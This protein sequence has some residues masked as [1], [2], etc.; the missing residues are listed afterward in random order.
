M[1]DNEFPPYLYKFKSLSSN[2]DI[3]YIREI[4]LENKLY[5]TSPLKFNDPFDSNPVRII[6]GTTKEKEMYFRRLCRENL[7]GTPRSERRA[8]AKKLARESSEVQKNQ[9]EEIRKHTMES[10]G[11][12]CF[13]GNVENILLWSHYADSH[14]GICLRFKGTISL[15]TRSNALPVTY[16]KDRPVLDLSDRDD[17]RYLEKALLTKSSDWS[18]EDEHRIVELSG[19]G[20]YEFSP[21]LLDGVIFGDRT[22]DARRAE[23]LDMIRQRTPIPKLLQCRIDDRHFRLLLETISL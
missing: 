14:R 2:E 16:S 17:G 5:L 4:L 9:L 8:R 6:G 1:L 10:V 22:S 23:V 19:P 12:H 11:I 15:R 20:H 18:Y 13:A 3:K 21:N 7:Q